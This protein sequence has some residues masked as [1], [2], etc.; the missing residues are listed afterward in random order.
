MCHRSDP[1]EQQPPFSLI[2]AGST[3][4]PFSHTCI[5]L[6]STVQL[7]VHIAK[8]PFSFPWPPF[9]ILYI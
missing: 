4:P 3:P 5:S 7:V 8:P 1:H 2:G 6:P 9:S